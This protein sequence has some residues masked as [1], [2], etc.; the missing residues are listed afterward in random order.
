LF[1]DGWLIPKRDLISA[2]RPVLLLAFGLVLLTVVV[3]GY[4]LHWLVPELP[5][6]AAFALGAVVSPPDAVSVNAIILKLKVPSRVT[7]IL[8][9][10]S[11]IND[12]SGLVAFKFAVAAAVTGA[13]SWVT[14]GWQFVVLSG[15]GFVLGVGVAWIIGQARVGLRRFCVA[16]PTIQTVISLLTPYAAYLAAEAL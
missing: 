7:T 6:A 4:V 9:G 15:V 1:S 11:L 3:V 16:D 12:A 13:F 8:N 14:A 10:Q 2:I 5:L